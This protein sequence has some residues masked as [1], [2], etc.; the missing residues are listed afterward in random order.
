VNRFGNF[1]GANVE[2]IQRGISLKFPSVQRTWVEDTLL[3]PWVRHIGKFTPFFLAWDEDAYPD[4]VFL[5][6]ADSSLS[7]VLGEG[8]QDILDLDIDLVG[9]DEA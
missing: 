2:F 3:A 6:R 8:P 4:E 7:D 5:V 1:I 9:V